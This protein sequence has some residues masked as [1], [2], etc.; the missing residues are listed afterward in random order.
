MALGELD[1]REVPFGNRRASLVDLLSDAEPLLYV[2]PATTD[3]QT[4]REW[5]KTFEGAGFD[6]LLAKDPAGVYVENKRTQIKVK[7]RHTVDA[8]VAGFRVHKSGNGIGSMMLG[9]YDDSGGLHHVGVCASFTQQKRVEM[10]EF[11]EPYAR[12]VED[13]PWMSWSEPSEHTSS[14]I[15]MPGAPNRWS[16]TKSADW[17]PVRIELVVEVSFEQLTAGRFRH[18]AR[19]VRWRPDREAESCLYDQVT[20]ASSPKLSEI[21]D[22]TS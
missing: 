16:G 19:F 12:D 15:R 13:H 8:V 5:F 1:L 18:P 11:L 17:T 9:L 7:H 2:S 14:G 6:G 4:A 21:F 10:L 22:L 3:N 20:I